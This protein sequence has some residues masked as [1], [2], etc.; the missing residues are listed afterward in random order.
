MGRVEREGRETRRIVLG[1]HTGTHCDA[2]RHFIAGKRGV[3][4]LPLDVL[5][6]PARVVDF[7]RSRP[8][9]QIAVSDLEREL[10]D[11]CPARVVMRFDWSAHWGKQDYYTHHPSISEESARW[12][13]ERGVRLLGMDTPS[14]G[15]SRSMSAPAISA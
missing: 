1:T 8:L 3:D 13:V 12:F 11:S 5:I 2:P 14:P 15:S 6:G 4:D 10:G 9:E 7:S